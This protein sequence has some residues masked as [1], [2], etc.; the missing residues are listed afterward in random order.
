MSDRT[1]TWNGKTFPISRPELSDEDVAGKVRMLMRN[2][3]NHESVCCLARERIMCLVSEVSALQAKIDALHSAQSYT[4]IGRD[5]KPVLARDMEDRAE[6]A[7]ARI[8][9]L[10]AAIPRAWEMGRDAAKSAALRGANQYM[11]E[12]YETPP[13]VYIKDAIRAITPPANLAEKIKEGE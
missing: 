4:Y 5:G 13:E 6:A 11:T 8:R 1:Y 2:Q 10:E 12:E 9:E 3:L 7:E